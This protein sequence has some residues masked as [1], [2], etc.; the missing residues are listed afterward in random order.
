MQ[1][2]SCYNNQSWSRIAQRF[3]GRIG[4]H[5]RERWHNQLWPDIQRDAWP[6]EEEEALIEADTWV[7]NG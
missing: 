1:T 4:K 7:G 5:C 2:G 3:P 6:A